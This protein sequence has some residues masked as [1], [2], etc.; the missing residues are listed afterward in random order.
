MS[1]LLSS[2]LLLAFTV[3]AACASP[4]ESLADAARGDTMVFQPRDTG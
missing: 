4:C 2:A 1:R 3:I